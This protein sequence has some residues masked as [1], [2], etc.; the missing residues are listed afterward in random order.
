MSQMEEKTADEIDNGRATTR[1][2]VFL[3]ISTDASIQNWVTNG[4]KHNNNNN[5]SMWLDSGSTVLCYF[6]AAITTF[7]A[8]LYE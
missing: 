6:L 8:S 1:G 3:K 4:G 2:N 5:S 7:K